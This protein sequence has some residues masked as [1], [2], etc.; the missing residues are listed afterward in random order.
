MRC[1]R[2][3]L[4]NQRSASVDPFRRHLSLQWLGHWPTA[5]ITTLIGWLLHF[6]ALLQSGVS[7]S[8]CNNLEMRSHRY[9][10]WF[11]PTQPDVR[12][13]LPHLLHPSL[14]FR[15]KRILSFLVRDTVKTTPQESISGSSPV[16]VTFRISLPSK[17]WGSGTH[18]SSPPS[19]W[20]GMSSLG[21]GNPAHER[22]KQTHTSLLQQQFSINEQNRSL[23][24]SL[25]YHD[26]RVRHKPPV[27]SVSPSFFF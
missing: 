7:I 9:D 17:S 4:S 1:S 3:W 14:A 11:K 10:L 21:I 20:E 18:C 2:R 8:S 15:N 27:P 5:L 24:S 22:R 13:C 25:G 16:Y 12:V 26:R 23:D 6:D 19:S